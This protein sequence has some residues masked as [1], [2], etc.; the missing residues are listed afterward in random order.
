[1]VQKCMLKKDLQIWIAIFF[2]RMYIFFLYQKNI[3]ENL[4]FNFLTKICEIR[5]K[6]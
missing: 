3:I 2:Y 4:K 6:R 5:K 1:M